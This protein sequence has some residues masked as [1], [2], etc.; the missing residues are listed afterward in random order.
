MDELILCFPQFNLEDKDELKGGIV[1]GERRKRGR[2]GGKDIGY[3]N[4]NPKMI[5]TSCN[6]PFH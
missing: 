4:S 1:T 3:L 6:I 2:G 5:V